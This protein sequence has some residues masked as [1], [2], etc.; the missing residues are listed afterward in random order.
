MSGTRS[1]R[2]A[3]FA[4]LIACTAGPVQGLRAEE[5]DAAAP[6][7]AGQPI[8]TVTVT[9]RAEDLTGAADSANQ[10]TVSAE[11]LALRPLLRPGE[12]VEQIPGVIITQHSGS[13]KANQYFLRGFNLDHG[14]DLAVSVDGVPVN[15]PTHAHGQGYAD[16]NFLIPELVD[17]VHYKKGPY[18]ADVGDFGS[19]GAFDI[20]YYDQLPSGLARVEGGQYG[21][22]RGVLANNAGLGE[23]NLIYAL[24]LEHNNGPWVNK[25]NERKIDGVLRYASGNVSDGFDVTGMAYYNIWNSTDQIP[26]RAIAGVADPVSAPPAPA[27]DLISRWG[28]IDPSD[29]GDSSRYSI[30][31]NWRH[32]GDNSV[33]RVSAYGL[34]YTLNLFSNFTYFLD[35]PIHG[36]QIEQEDKRYVFGGQATQMWSHDLFGL[37][38][39]TTVGIELRNDDIHNGLFH[40]EDRARLGTTHLDD[41][42]ETSLNPFLENETH[43]TD[44][45]R[46]IIGL[47]GDV[48]W[49]DVANITGGNSGSTTAGV[50]SPKANVI[51]GPWDKTELYLNFGQGFHSNDAR[52]VVA[53]TNPSTPLPRSTGAEVGLRTSIIPG[54]RSEVSLW[55]LKLQSELVWDGDAGDNQP[56]GPTR[57]YGVEFANWYT[58]T[59]WLTVDADFAWSHARFTDFEPDGNY[60]PEAL[61][62]TFDGGFAVHDIP[63]GLAPWSAGLR[64][65]YFGPRP[66]TQD[67]SVKSK[68][69][70]L[71]YADVGYKIS[72]VWSLGLNVFNLL[73]SHAS[74]IDYFY[75]S[76]LPGEAAPVNDIHTHP[77]EPQELR[78]FLTARL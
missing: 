38:S 41:V 7:S 17:Q 70:T 26:A 22:G 21:Y 13:G 48:Y 32:S 52:G 61:V 18:Y 6:Q 55:L 33:T 49:M 2:P 5:I 34:Y 57:R 62:T 36:D 54:L 9:G 78:L 43:W 50:V 11:D 14:T 45:L 66:L 44:W 3:A 29:G 69:T 16:L 76:R 64:L 68:A 30:S 40:T 4:L 10:G 51:F 25:D 65:R 35:D 27:T 12:V 77:S 67:A 72:D 19:A 59:A 75:E 28:E 42:T 8:D 63:G 53:T 71:L 15:M 56:S 31:G 37:P 46:T 20:H 74:D 1:L 60:V 24:E 23:G 58:P 73:N 39:A 47:R